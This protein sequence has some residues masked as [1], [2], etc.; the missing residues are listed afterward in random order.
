[1]SNSSSDSHSLVQ[2][3]LA[4]AESHRYAISYEKAF[5]ILDVA[6]QIQGIQPADL[7]AIRLR[8]LAY[9]IEYCWLINRLGLDFTMLQSQLD[10]TYENAFLRHDSAQMAENLFLTGR[11]HHFYLFEST[12]PDLDAVEQAWITAHDHYQQLNDARGMAESLFYHGLLYQRCPCLAQ[13]QTLSD[14]TI[15]NISPHRLCLSGSR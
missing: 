12:S 8:K 10:A 5:E 3:H 2:S 1:M 4:L 15:G 9:Q 6:I 7:N 14:R 11:L 13:R